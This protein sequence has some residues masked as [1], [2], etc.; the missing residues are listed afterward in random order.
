MI[1]WLAAQPWS[2]GRVGMFGTSYS[3]FNSIQMACE[4]PPALGAI[5]AIYAT[6][7]RYT[8]DVHYMGGALRA[9][10]L[11]DYCH[12]MTP[13]R[14]AAPCPRCS[15]TAGATSGGGGWSRW[16]PGC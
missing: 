16:S 4:Q 6:D 8:D 1:A 14:R 5:C 13:M 7:D 9:V 3:G 10:D 2:N 15:E 12:Y 11:V